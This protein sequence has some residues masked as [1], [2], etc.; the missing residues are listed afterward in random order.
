ML[1]AT[2]RPA[3]TRLTTTSTPAAR[4][5]AHP[6]AVGAGAHPGTPGSTARPPPPAKQTPHPKPGTSTISNRTSETLN[7]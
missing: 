5:E 6:G 3:S 4:K 2:M 1:A 7:D